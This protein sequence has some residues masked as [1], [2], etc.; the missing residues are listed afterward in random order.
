MDKAEEKEEEC[1]K[2]EKIVN[3]ESSKR[4]LR[5]IASKPF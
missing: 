3:Q 2:A 4:G 1:V 5:I